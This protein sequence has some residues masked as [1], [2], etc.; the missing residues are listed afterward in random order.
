[1]KVA[2]LE[3]KKWFEERRRDYVFWMLCVCVYP[4]DFD[5]LLND[6]TL[7]LH[8]YQSSSMMEKS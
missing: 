8:L 1:M 7:L 5:H 3:S 4:C 6:L 2:G